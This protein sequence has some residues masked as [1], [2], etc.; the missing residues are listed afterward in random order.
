MPENNDSN[1]LTFLRKETRRLRNSLDKLT[2]PLEIL[3][4]RRG[5]RV[6]KKDPVEDL[7]IP[8]EKLLDRYY[9][10]LQRYS[11]RLFL[12]DVI[13]YQNFF[14]REDVT[15]YATADISSDYLQYLLD[16]KIATKD[17]EG[18]HLARPVKSFGE[19]LE[20]FVAELLRRE[21][22]SEAIWGVKFK[23]PLV[24][25]D[26]DVLGKFDG[27]IMYIEVKSSPPKQVYAAEISAFLDRVA[28][29]VPEVAVFFM[30]TEL[31]MKDK[32][33]PMFEDELRRRYPS[34]PAVRR[35]EKELFEIEGRIFI[36]N[37]KDSVSGNIA[38]VLDWYFRRRICKPA[39]SH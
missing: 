29:L 39:K 18:F 20:W 21:F 34:P 23:R 3:L 8:S 16:A 5:F 36:M 10:M 37:A 30:D 11:F 38:K 35:M 4:K 22:H 19:T 14:S 6:F 27:S 2:S 24:G 7:L 32:I 33:V 25:G 15:R 26:Y 28:D 13:K 12:R 17:G 9:L 1:E 31:R